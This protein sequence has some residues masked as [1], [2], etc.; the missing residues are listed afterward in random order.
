MQA[1]QR[2][3]ATHYLAAKAVMEKAATEA[4]RLREIVTRARE[5][6]A[7]GKDP[8]IVGYDV[9]TVRTQIPLIDPKTAADKPVEVAFTDTRRVHVTEI[10]PRPAGYIVQPQARAVIEA[11]GT[12][13]VTLC[14]AEHGPIPAEAFMVRSK[15][16]PVNRESINPEQAVE[17]TLA[18]RT[19]TP[20]DGAVFV[21]MAQ[22]AAAVVSASLEPDSPGS[23]V[24][25]GLVP[26]A[27]SGEAPIYRVPAGSPAPIAGRCGS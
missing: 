2:R 6:I 10:R 13:G 12:R 23:Y 3:V 9:E 14:A 19:V 25:V 21:P 7:G 22:A 20:S 5:A 1:Y 24:G 15:P 4:G 8:L 17:V 18:A 11:L 27:Q 26:V 16:G